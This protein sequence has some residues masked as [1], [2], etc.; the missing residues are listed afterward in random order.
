MNRCK[1]QQKSRVRAIV[2]L[3]ALVMTLASCQTISSTDTST[4][5]AATAS[6]A[7]Q[8]ARWL[9]TIPCRAPCWEGVT[10]GQTTP[11]AAVRLL[12]QSP[13]IT[14]VQQIEFHDVHLGYI[15]WD[16]LTHQKGGEAHYHTDTLT[17]T[18][19]NIHPYIEPI[20]LGDRANAL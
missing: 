4:T 17:Q 19:E 1:P 8:A 20:Y 5:S 15:T 11:A 12:Q 13:I 14:N 9:Q 10:P 7:I 18:I 16:W 3:V 2:I 6:S